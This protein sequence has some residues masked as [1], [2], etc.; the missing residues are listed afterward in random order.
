MIQR[1][2]DRIRSS[3]DNVSCGV[4]HVYVLGS[5]F[6]VI[7]FNDIINVIKHS[8]LKIDADDSRRQQ[9]MTDQTH[10]QLYLFAVF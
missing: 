2:T 3:S 1:V 4:A 9:A 7:H 6:F 5:F 10:I 8:T